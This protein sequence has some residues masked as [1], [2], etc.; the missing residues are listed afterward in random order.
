[1]PSREDGN[2][3]RISYTART[4]HEQPDRSTFAVGDTAVRRRRE[5]IRHGSN[6]IDRD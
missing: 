3:A 1:M 2:N 6:D 5:P 4:A